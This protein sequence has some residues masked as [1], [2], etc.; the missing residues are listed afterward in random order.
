MEGRRGKVRGEM[1]EAAR[2]ENCFR[3]EDFCIQRKKE[4]D[5]RKN[6]K[7]YLW[8]ETSMKCEKENK[9][10]VCIFVGHGLRSTSFVLGDAK[11][12]EIRICSTRTSLTYPSSLS[13]AGTTAA[14]LDY[15]NCKET[16]TNYQ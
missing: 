10:Y 16:R 11:K 7:G 12:S 3:L 8:R 6:T 5:K 4:K 9:V 15:A 13:Q 1:Y 14:A 2:H